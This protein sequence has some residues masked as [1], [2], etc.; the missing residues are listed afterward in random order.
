MKTP[1]AL[2]LLGGSAGLLGMEVVSKN[3]GD[4]AMGGCCFSEACNSASITYK[5]ARSST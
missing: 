4:W 3:P 1:R 5:Q 2:E